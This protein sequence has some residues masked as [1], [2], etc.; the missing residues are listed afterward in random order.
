[1]SL[2]HLATLADTLSE[3][4]GALRSTASLPSDGI[5]LFDNLDSD[6]DDDQVGS[7]LAPTKAVAQ[8]TGLRLFDE[9]KIQWRP[10]E[11]SEWAM[12]SNAASAFV[13]HDANDRPLDSGVLEQ[14]EELTAHDQHHLRS[15]LTA[16]VTAGSP[17][18]GFRVLNA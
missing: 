7:L 5:V 2:P 15:N 8:P 14:L 16:Y 17:A 13:R 12:E 18:T 1:M 11:L 3:V 10:V 4:A 6:S 9:N